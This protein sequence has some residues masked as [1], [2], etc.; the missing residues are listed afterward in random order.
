MSDQ[1]NTP[2]ANLPYLSTL[3][4][5]S[6]AD[7]SVLHHESC[8]NGTD[9]DTAMHASLGFSVPWGMHTPDQEQ[10]QQQQY[11]Q[12]H[13]LQQQHPEQQHPEPQYQLEHH[14]QSWPG[15]QHT[16]T[17]FSHGNTTNFVPTWPDTNTLNSSPPASLDW[18][19]EM[20]PTGSYD[21]DW[22]LSQVL[23]HI[24][25]GPTVGNAGLHVA[26][27]PDL[28]RAPP[29][30]MQSTSSAHSDFG[31]TRRGNRVEASFPSV[32][33]TTRQEDLSPQGSI[34]DGARAGLPRHRAA[35]GPTYKASENCTCH[36]K[37]WPSPKKPRRVRIPVSRALKEITRD[38]RRSAATFSRR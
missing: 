23:H 13:Y 24:P 5:H 32:G 26:S 31:V 18:S 16:Q 6:V 35:H 9:T 27:L 12:L 28:E 19:S 1:A 7:S 21:V 4:A 2:S 3:E 38:E 30:E 29:T 34:M 17:P 33:W 11:Q 10:Q 22:Y 15:Q 25:L 37:T 8:E 14:Q 36:A 20:R